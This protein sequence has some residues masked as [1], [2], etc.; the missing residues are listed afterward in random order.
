MGITFLDCSKFRL[1]KSSVQGITRVFQQN[2]TSEH[3]PVSTWKRS[4]SQEI[5]HEANDIAS[6]PGFRAIR[7][8]LLSPS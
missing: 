1:E 4:D 7:L 5:N 6:G 2:H 3:M 8:F